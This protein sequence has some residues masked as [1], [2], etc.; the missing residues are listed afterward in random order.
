M[1]DIFSSF[2]LYKIVFILELMVAMAIS[3]HGLR[4]RTHFALRTVLAVSAL[5]LVAWF[6]PIPWY[7]SLYASFLFLSLFLLAVAAACF[8]FDEPFYHILFCGITAYTAQHIAYETFNFLLTIAGV[9]HYGDMYSS[10]PP[11]SSVFVLLIYAAT[12]SL[13]YWVIW[14]LVSYCVYSDDDLDIGDKWT[15]LGLVSVIV[16]VDVV[17]NAVLVYGMADSEL[18]LAANVVLYLQSVLCCSLAL[19]VHFALLWREREKHE[20]IRV[21]ELWNADRAMYERFQENLDLINIKCHDLKH[22]IS[23]LRQKQTG[24]SDDRLREIEEAIAIYDCKIKTGNPVLD[25]ILAERT[26]QCECEKIRF[27]CIVE[28]AELQFI[29]PDNLYS[30]FGNA[31]SNA[32]EAVKKTEDAEKKLIHL[33]VYRRNHMVFIH[34]DNYCAEA[35]IPK[36]T[37]GFPETT[38]ADKENHGYGMRSMYMMAEKLGGSME[39]HLSDEIFHLNIFI[40]I[41]NPY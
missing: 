19:A 32:I 4:R 40:P 21:K 33:Y 41:P 35:E 31:I 25:T 24:V 9:A 12:Y 37:N 10:A 11:S 29:S 30:L 1:F 36:I 34:I 28:G 22:Q 17:L 38:K 23:E 3:M 13:V 5:M 14:I 8:C 2:S 15:K 7:H 20:V 27:I 39:Y 6:F 26:L 18:P 16:L